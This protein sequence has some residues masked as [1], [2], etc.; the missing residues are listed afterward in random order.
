[1]ARNIEIK[2]RIEGIEA[3]LAKLVPLADEGPIEILQDDWFFGCES[4]RLKLR[5]LSNTEGE[6][7]F[8]R[9]K[10][11]RRRKPR[12]ALGSST[13]LHRCCW[14]IFNNSNAVLLLSRLTIPSCCV[15]AEG[16]LFRSFRATD[17]ERG[18]NQS[19]AL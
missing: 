5:V 7:I 12:I 14:T 11:T 15:Q 6:L 10:Q 2:A 13:L 4:G 1:M 18:F 19:R 3:L 17:H 9:R 8:Y 16:S